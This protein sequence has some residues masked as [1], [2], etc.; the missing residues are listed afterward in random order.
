MAV[1]PRSL[2]AS[3]LHDSL[4]SSDSQHAHDAYIITHALKEPFSL[5][6]PQGAYEAQK[7]SSYNAQAP[8]VNGSEAGVDQQ[9]SAYYNAQASMGGVGSGFAQP[10]QP[11]MP[12]G[13]MSHATASQQPQ[14]QQYQHQQRPYWA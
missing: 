13:G 11:Y 12:V 9:R 6:L 1:F 10:S 2:S 8:A 3:G 14:Q 5:C 7:T 4:F